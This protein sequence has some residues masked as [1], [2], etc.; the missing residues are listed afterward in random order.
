MFVFCFA[1]LV[2]CLELEFSLGSLRDTAE[3]EAASVLDL[4]ASAVIEAGVKVEHVRH[5]AEADDQR[6]VAIVLGHHRHR[7]L[8]EQNSNIPLRHDA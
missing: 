7:P 3:V 1:Y 4:H 8:A 6:H 2:R 5:L